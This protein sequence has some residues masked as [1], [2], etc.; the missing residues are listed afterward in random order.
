M[1]KS[2]PVAGGVVLSNSHIIAGPISTQGAH[3]M[4]FIVPWLACLF[5]VVLMRA[6]SR[7]GGRGGVW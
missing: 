3:T 1:M 6:C 5:V 2:L 4:L 7:F